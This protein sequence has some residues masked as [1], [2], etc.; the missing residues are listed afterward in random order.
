MAE[1]ESAV[2]REWDTMRIGLRKAAW[3]LLAAGC[4]LVAFGSMEA[5]AI[6][7]DDDVPAI[8]NTIRLE[9]QISGLGPQGA[10]VAIK[11]AH[12]GCKFKTIEKTIPK[13]TKAEVFKLDPIAVAATSVSADRDCSF[14]ITVSEPGREAKVFKRGLRLMAPAAGATEIPSRTLK[15]YLPTTALASKDDAKNPKTRR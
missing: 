4:G 6:D 3:L 8:E 5:R 2:S 13:G 14:E 12:A 15:C 11:P 7:G 9:I 1:I 10:K